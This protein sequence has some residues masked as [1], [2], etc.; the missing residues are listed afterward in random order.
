[1]ESEDLVKMGWVGGEGGGGGGN[2][3]GGAFK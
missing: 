1:M 2:E 3:K